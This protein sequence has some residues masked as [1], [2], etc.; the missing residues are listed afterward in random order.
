MFHRPLGTT[1]FTAFM[2]PTTATHTLLFANI[3]NRNISFQ[4]KTFDRL[5]DDQKLLFGGSFKAFSQT[6]LSDFDAFAPDLSVTIVNQILEVLGS[7]YF[8]Q[9]ILFGS[10]QLVDNHAKTD[11]DTYWAGLI[12]AKLLV[13]QG[14]LSESQ[15]KVLPVRCDIS[16]NDGLLRYYRNQLKRFNID[17]MYPNV[18]I[19]DAGGSP[20][21]KVALKLMAEFMVDSQKLE[22][23]YVNAKTKTLEK[24][25]QI[26]YR[27]IITAEQVRSLTAKGQYKAAL[28]L[29]QVDDLTSLCTTRVLANRL[30][31]M[32][33]FLSIGNVEM[34]QKLRRN[35]KQKERD[36]YAFLV[37]SPS[38]LTNTLAKA[39]FMNR[40]G[41]FDA[42]IL[43]F[44]VFY[45]K[46][47]AQ[48]IHA[49]FGYDLVNEYY[50]E[51]RR[52]RQEA[53]ERFPH[54]ASE[55]NLESIAEMVFQVKVAQCIQEEPHA[56]FVNTLSNFIGGKSTENHKLL[57]INVVRNKIA[58][59]GLIPDD[60][61]MGKDL[62]Y[63]A[64]LIGAAGQLMQLPSENIFEKL[65]EAIALEV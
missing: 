57:F 16:D 56:T 8:D 1:S 44:A 3:G 38:P 50:S 12:M 23:L 10:D 7:A 52:L 31:G 49:H 60:S 42:A 24:V 11:Q 54:L 61:M 19:C 46:Y 34:Y 65:N 48:L 41:Q 43:S 37:E 6:L 17:Y 59:E 9:V 4:G 35:M 55:N 51:S 63:F 62:P 2:N 53:L 21:Q 15:V 64:E 14:Y 29:R 58:H 25:S 26:E 47:L 36:Q 22:V 33:Y 18:C 40:A 28:S 39:Q 13:R 5:S 45:E 32:G 27:N 20:Q 30:L